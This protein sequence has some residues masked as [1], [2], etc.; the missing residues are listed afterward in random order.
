MKRTIPANPFAT[1]QGSSVR[2][3][4]SAVSKLSNSLSSCCSKY[5]SI[6]GASPSTVNRLSRRVPPSVGSSS[7]SPITFSSRER[8]T[9]SM[10][11]TGSRVVSSVS[12]ITVSS[13]TGIGTERYYVACVSS[14]SSNSSMTLSELARFS[15]SER[16]DHMSRGGAA[17]STVR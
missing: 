1:H 13:T 6:P 7:C 2:S 16:N 5:S 14:F 9:N 12:M 8:P 3:F 15:G 17:I 4:R 10:Y 11:S